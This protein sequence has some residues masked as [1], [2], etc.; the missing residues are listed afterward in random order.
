[1][2]QFEHYFLSDEKLTTSRLFFIPV[3]ASTN[4]RTLFSYW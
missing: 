1:M 4:L 3:K 2:C